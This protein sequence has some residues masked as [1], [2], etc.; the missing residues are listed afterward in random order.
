MTGREKPRVICGTATQTIRM[1]VGACLLSVA[2]SHAAPLEAAVI[3]SN[4]GPGDSFMTAPGI[5]PVWNLSSGGFIDRAASFT[6]PG[7][8]DVLFGSADLGFHSQTGSNLAAIILAENDASNL[9]GAVIETMTLLLPAPSLTPTIVTAMSST[10]PILEA[11]STYWI[12]ASLPDVGMA[13]WGPN[14][15]GVIGANATRTNFQNG[16]W[17]DQSASPTPSLR[18]HSVAV[19]EPATMSLLAFALAALAIRRRARARR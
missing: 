6:V 13:T 11:G 5:Y 4:L 1:V 18:I 19:P 17:F 12:I 2:V 15:T 7:S 16:L 10:N 9:P 3:Y 8:E 14:D